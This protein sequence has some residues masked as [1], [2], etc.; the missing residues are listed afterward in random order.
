[1][2]IF[3]FQAED[4]MRVSTVTGVQTC[5]LPILLAALYLLKFYRRLSPTLASSERRL[6]RLYRSQ[7]D[8]LAALSWLR[9]HGES[10]Q[11]FARRVSSQVPAFERTTAALV[12]TTYGS[13]D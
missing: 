10:R 3:F 6:R 8:R 2:Y 4:C 7:L 12:A 1:M 9:G 5:A 13:S 11:A